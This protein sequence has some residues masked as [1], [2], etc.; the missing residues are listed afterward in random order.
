MKILNDNVDLFEVLYDNKIIR[1]IHV[2]MK[3]PGPI[4]NR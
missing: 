2:I 4:S 3:L 1:V